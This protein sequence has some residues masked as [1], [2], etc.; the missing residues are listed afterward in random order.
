MNSLLVENE[1]VG[2]VG[3]TKFDYRLDIIN[4]MCYIDIRFYYGI[5]INLEQ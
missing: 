2:K 4:I 3:V 5:I 1:M